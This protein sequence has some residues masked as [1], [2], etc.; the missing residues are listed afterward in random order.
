MTHSAPTAQI[1]QFV[2]TFQAIEAGLTDLIVLLT[3][4]DDEYVHILISELEYNSRVRATDV[5]FSRFVALNAQADESAPTE[6]HKL[7]SEL[8]KLGER[9]NAVVHSRYN[10]LVL[11]DGTLGLMRR[12]AKL[13]PSKGSRE[14]EE[15]DLLPESLNDDLRRLEDGLLR[16]E[17]FRQKVVEWKFPVT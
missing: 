7:M 13:R 5:A 6:F 2:V 14:H 15:E 11:T 10:I 8:L 3:G 9:R 17:R 4:A 16:L 1:G 12:N